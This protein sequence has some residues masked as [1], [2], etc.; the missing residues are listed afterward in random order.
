MKKIVQTDLAPQAIGP[1]S[2]AVKVTC[3]E[4]LYVSGNIPL[5]PKT[6][7]VVGDTAV[8]QCKLVM[9][10]LGQVLKAGGAEYSQ[11]VKTTIYL[12]DMND[13]AAINEVYASYFKEN[14]PARATV[15]VS[16]LPK[17]VKIEIDA[18]AVLS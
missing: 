11:V 9:D 12:T 4:T 7:E 14:P 3:A 18:I 13:F 6:M 5:D 17:D 1:Y 8:E 15:E 16:R 2:Q 10:N